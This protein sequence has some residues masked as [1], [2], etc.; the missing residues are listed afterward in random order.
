MP[1]RVGLGVRERGPRRN[2]RRTETVT[3]F[4][5]REFPDESDRDR[6]VHHQLYMPRR[7]PEIPGFDFHRQ[8]GRTP[9]RLKGLRPA[10]SRLSAVLSPRETIGRETAKGACAWIGSP[11]SPTSF[12]ASYPAFSS[13]RPARSSCSAGSVACRPVSALTPLVIAGGLIELVGGLL[14]MLGLFTRAA[15]F[16]ASGEM[17]VAYFLYSPAGRLLADPEPW[18]GG[19][20]ALLHLPL[21]CGPTGRGAGAWT[22]G[23]RNRR[24]PVRA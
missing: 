18:R 20:P 2:R 23:S 21:L 5:H 19:R 13:S 9:F 16:I 4:C 8:I 1:P 3:A 11:E 17:A 12:S 10:R 22:H 15:A 6:L 7:G 24:S 14:I